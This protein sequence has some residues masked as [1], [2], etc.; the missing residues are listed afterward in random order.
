MADLL[1]EPHSK[2]PRFN[3]VVEISDP[4]FSHDLFDL[5]VSA[6]MRAYDP[7]V[8]SPVL[9]NA[10]L[11]PEV[12]KGSEVMALSLPSSVGFEE[13]LAEI[14]DCED[15]STDD[16][17]DVGCNVN[18]LSKS[19]RFGEAQVDEL[20]II[21]AGGI[22]KSIRVER[23]AVKAFD[24]W[25]EHRGYATIKSIADLSEEVDVKPLINMLVFFFLEVKKQD[26]T[27]YNPT[28]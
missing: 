15:C 19:K 11:P 23:W 4:H 8:K 22:R 18:V 17:A 24:D 13:A 26:G 10:S 21:E 25:R 20:K 14:S 6:H 9:V 27:L 7:D 12:D 1:N 28:T 3:D 2:R 16:E 5:G